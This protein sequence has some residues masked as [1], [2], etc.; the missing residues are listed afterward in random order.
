MPRRFLV[1]LIAVTALAATAAAP[2][3]A[4]SV[5]QP[6]YTKLNLAGFSGDPGALPSAIDAIEAASGGKVVEIRFNNVGGVPGYDVV[7]ARGSQITFERF[8]KPGQGLITLSGETK[9][10]WMLN[11]TARED[12]TLVRTAK[13]KLADAVRTAEAARGNAPA[14]AAGIAKSAAG[15][16][17][18]VK[19]YNVAII[20]DGRQHRV[21]VDS[22][23]G[24]VI[25]N[26]RM[27]AAW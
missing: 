6:A 13:V 18:D 17:T 24:E 16:N 3:I 8:A 12:V 14:A 15:A 2:A 25:A 1:S 22:A 20:Q 26:P 21:A 5:D 7:L 27:L 4:Q 19:A 10:A 23:T 9:P 11:W